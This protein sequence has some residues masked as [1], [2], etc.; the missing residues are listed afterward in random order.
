M[1]LKK[2]K[3]FSF[4]YKNIRIYRFVMNILYSGKY[5]QRFKIIENLLNPNNDKTIVELCFGDIQIS[6]ST[7]QL[8]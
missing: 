2:R 6:I 7:I 1:D 8:I 3:K 5:Y 4:I